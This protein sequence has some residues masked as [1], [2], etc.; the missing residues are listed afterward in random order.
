MKVTKVDAG[1]AGEKD[2][3]PLYTEQELAM[4]YGYAKAEEICKKLLKTNFVTP[5]EYAEI[6]RLNKESFHPRLSEIMA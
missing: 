5:E 1:K 3:T 6:M 4:E 2:N